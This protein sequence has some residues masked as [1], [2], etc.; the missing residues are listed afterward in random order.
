[1]SH[2]LAGNRSKSSICLHFHY[3]NIEL[4]NFQN[5]LKKIQLTDRVRILPILT[6]YT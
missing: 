2:D 4:K 5:S 3:N 6:I 1:M